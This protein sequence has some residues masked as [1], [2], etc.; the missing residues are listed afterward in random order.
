MQCSMAVLAATATA[1]DQQ[2]H[3]E[4]RAAACLAARSEPALLEGRKQGLECSSMAAPDAKRQKTGPTGLLRPATRPH[5]LAP[6]GQGICRMDLSATAAAAAHPATAGSLALP[7]GLVMPSRG[8][9]A[10]A[11]NPKTGT[12][13][14]AQ[15]S[16]ATAVPAASQQAASRQR[17]QRPV[18]LHGNYSRYYGYRLGYAFDEDPRMQVRGFLQGF[19][20]GRVCIVAGSCC[21][22]MSQH[23]SFAPSF[24][25]LQVFKRAW[26]QGRRCLDIGCNSGAITL[27]IAAQLAPRS[28]LGVD[29]DASL[30]R[31]ACRCKAP[32]G[33]LGMGCDVCRLLVLHVCSGAAASANCFLVA[34]GACSL[35]DGLL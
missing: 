3:H 15:A 27:S 26:F 1:A 33:V 9:A 14:A 24:A 23:L 17:K 6:A 34:A 5:R 29:I 30:I 8:P 18:F 4:C 2:Q 10:A 32:A 19:Q 11:Q 16:D 13:A 22:L 28:M 35:R 31:K 20:L 25:W 21:S 7:A 12:A